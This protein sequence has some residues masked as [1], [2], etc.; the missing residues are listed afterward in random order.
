LR[1]ILAAA[2]P[3]LALAGCGPSDAEIRNEVREGALNSC[4]A[5]DRTKAPPGFD[6]RRFCT[7][8]TDRIVAGRS[9]R[10]LKQ[11]APSEA[12]RREAVALCRAEMGGAS[13]PAR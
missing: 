10:E 9:G 6:W 12:E 4:L 2:L 8:V 3:L 5:A 1:K 13:V 7:C 11:Q